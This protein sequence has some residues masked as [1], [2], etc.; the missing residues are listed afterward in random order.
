MIAGESEQAPRIGVFGPLGRST[1]LN[2]VTI[3]H[4]CSSFRCKFYSCATAPLGGLGRKTRIGPSNPL[5]NRHQNHSSLRPN[6]ELQTC[7]AVGEGQGPGV[8][9][10]TRLSGD[11]DAEGTLRIGGLG[12]D[13]SESPLT[14]RNPS[15]IAVQR[16][17]RRYCHFTAGAPE[18]WERS[19]DPPRV[20]LQGRPATG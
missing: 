4:L 13:N 12:L 20:T 19:A 3:T 8:C 6:P 2:T 9:I 15:S 11:W 10:L 7:H 17:Y 1:A 14:K 5:F 18:A 16:E